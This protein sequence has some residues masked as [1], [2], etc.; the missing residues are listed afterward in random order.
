M[1]VGKYVYAFNIEYD[2]DPT[3]YSPTPSYR[4]LSLRVIFNCQGDPMPSDGPIGSSSTALITP[5]AE[6]AYPKYAC[7]AFFE[8][9]DNPGMFHDVRNIDQLLAGWCPKRL[10]NDMTGIYDMAD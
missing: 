1:P 4:Y 10:G 7:Q 2:C 5:G 3:K 9:A 8:K 6:W